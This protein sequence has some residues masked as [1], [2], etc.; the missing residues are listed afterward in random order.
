M[1][2]RFTVKGREKNLQALMDL[3]MTPAERKEILLGLSPDDY[4]AGPKPDD[5]DDTKS[6]WVFGK[7]VERRNIYIKLRVVQLKK[8][9]G[10]YH[11]T[12]WSFHPA[13]HALR[14]PLR[15][16]EA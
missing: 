5:T 4:V 1:L 13:E 16:G 7:K 11:A 6:V 2:D 15:G 14:Y 10:A 12:I 8:T 3:G 9:R